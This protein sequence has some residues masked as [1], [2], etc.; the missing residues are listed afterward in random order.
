MGREELGVR[1]RWL[2]LLMFVWGVVCCS[3]QAWCDEAP[4]DSIR[5]KMAANRNLN[6]D[7]PA[8]DRPIVPP[9]GGRYDWVQYNTGEWLKGEISG[10]Y[11]QSFEFDSEKFNTLTKNFEDVEVFYSPRRHTYVLYDRS[12]HSGT[13]FMKDGRIV[14]LTAD[15]WISFSRDDLQFI[16]SAKGSELSYWSFRASLGLTG[17]FNTSNQVSFSASA[18]VG[19]AGPKIRYM[20][21][22]RASFGRRDEE[23]TANNQ[24]FDTSVDLVIFESGYLRMLMGSIGYDQ[25]QNIN[26]RATVGMGFGLF[27]FQM[28]RLTVR[29][30]LGAVYQYIN[31]DEDPNSETAQDSPHDPAVVPGF[32]ISAD[33]TNDVTLTLS[34]QSTL[35]FLNLGHS[36]F[37]SSASFDMNLWNDL[38]DLTISGSWSRAA[39]STVSVSGQASTQNSLDLTI[40]LSVDVR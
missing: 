11:Q 19:R 20:N 3:S 4:V 30:E 40:G 25:F 9:S 34:H 7:P 8:Y 13:A 37:D 21:K 38:L 31:Y 23:V 36:Y 2:Q 5:S 32:Y 39:T 35:T 24:W 22:Y 28:K 12:Y 15:G 10:L 1:V 29:F 6:V 33:L 16:L 17:Q 14:V 18:Q 26:L 27:A